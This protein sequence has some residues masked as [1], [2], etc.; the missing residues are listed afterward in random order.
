MTLDQARL[1]ANVNGRAQRLFEDGYRA[2]WTG[3]AILAVHNGTETVY[4]VDTQAEACDC[5]FFLKSGHPCKHVLGWRRLLARQRACRLWIAALLLR[6][7]SSLDDAPPEG[8]TENLAV[9][10]GRTP[11]GPGEPVRADGRT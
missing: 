7:W 11:E 10:P 1:M 4:R 3:R 5:P 6:M 9:T 8:G 2:R